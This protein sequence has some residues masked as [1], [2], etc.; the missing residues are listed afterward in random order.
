M[1]LLYLGGASEKKIRQYVCAVVA[2][3]L[4][5]ISDVMKSAWTYSVALD[6]S[7]HQSTSYLDI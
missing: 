4:Q 5:N 1:H 2:I 3:S 6:A 7:M